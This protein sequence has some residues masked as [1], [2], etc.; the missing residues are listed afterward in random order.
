MLPNDWQTTCVPL[1]SIK[2]LH[3]YVDIF[4]LFDDYSNCETP[5][6]AMGQVFPN[7]EG[8]AI[9][10][11]DHLSKTISVFKNIGRVKEF[12]RH[13]SN[14]RPLFFSKDHRYDSNDGKNSNFGAEKPRDTDRWRPGFGG[15]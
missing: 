13:I 4:S 9:L 8:I 6:T 5:T 2:V 11:L 10:G 14:G 7:L 12:C 1:T 15:Y 3:P